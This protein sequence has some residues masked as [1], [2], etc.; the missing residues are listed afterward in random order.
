MSK[1]QYSTQTKLLFFRHLKYLEYYL[2]WIDRLIISAS[3]PFEE[4]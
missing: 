2:W 4:F 3:E 1:K